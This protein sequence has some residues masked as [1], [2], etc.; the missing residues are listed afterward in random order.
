MAL[1]PACRV[2]ASAA[3]A[4]LVDTLYSLTAE[5]YVKIW[6]SEK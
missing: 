5:K 4:T 2:V 6:K 3:S 1:N